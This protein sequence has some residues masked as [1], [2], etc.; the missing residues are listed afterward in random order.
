MLQSLVILASQPRPSPYAPVSP[1]PDLESRYATLYRHTAPLFTANDPLRT[2]F[3]PLLC[4]HKLTNRSSGAID[5]QGLYFHDLTNSFFR[6]CFIF[7]SIQIARGVCP[8]ALFR[9]SLRFRLAAPS[10]GISPQ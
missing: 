5:L 4:F 2:L 7:T 9:P 1:Q 10:R 3:L 8:F 6:K